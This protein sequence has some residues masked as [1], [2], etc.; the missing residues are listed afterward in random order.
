[1]LASCS[2]SD[3][4]PYRVKPKALGVMNE[5]VVVTDDAIWNS[6]I[7][8]TVDYYFGGYYPLTHRPEPIFDLRQY[9]INE[10]NTQPLKKE[11]RTYLFLA[12][13][14]NDSSEVT[15]VVKQ[16]LG[17]TGLQRFR[18]DPEFR[19]SVGR[20]KWA[21]GQ[22]LIYVFA[23]SLDELANA[24][25]V[26]HDAIAA[27]INAHDYRQ[28]YQSTFAKGENL[29]LSARLRERFGADITIPNGYQVVIDDMEDNGLIWLRFDDNE[30]TSNLVIRQFDYESTDQLDKEAVKQNLN[31]FGKKHVSSPEEGSYM[32]LNDVDLPILSFDRTVANHYAKE[33]RG[34]WEMENDFMGGPF[35]SYVIVNEEEAKVLQMDGFVYAPGKRKRNKLQQLELII[36]NMKW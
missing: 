1:M 4:N 8:D 16:D 10:I 24:I 5:I 23:E 12:D 19:T 33:F 30:G 6:M 34:I 25:E 20:D 13:M 31:L 32:A 21:T 7:G 22:I 11:L 3:D 17:A 14:S 27:R 15:Q 36:R 9:N 29:G 35:L 2:I 26:H 28:L 18:T